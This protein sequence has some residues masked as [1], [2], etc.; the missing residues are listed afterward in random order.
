MTFEEVDYVDNENCKGNNEEDHEGK[1]D[2]DEAKLVVLTHRNE[3]H[4]NYDD[5]NFI[6]LISFNKNENDKNMKA[7]LHGCSN[8]STKKIFK[9]SIGAN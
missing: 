4:C 5:D 7:K 3:K 2:D 1:D 6:M 8:I 9:N